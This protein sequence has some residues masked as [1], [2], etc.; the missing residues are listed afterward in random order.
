MSPEKE[1]PVHLIRQ[2]VPLF[3]IGAARSGTTIV[4]RILDAHPEILMTNE[5]TVFLQLSHIIE[6]SRD[7]IKSGVIYGKEYH[8]LWADHLLEYAK[9]LIE[10]YYAKIAAQRNAQQL[11]YWGDKH[12]HHS[13][14][15]SFID[16]LYPEARYIYILRDPR[17]VACSIAK[18]NSGSF[19]QA[20]SAWK[21]FTIKYER[22]IEKLD[23]GRIYYLR[24]EELVGD[25]TKGCRQLL[26]WLGLDFPVQVEKFLTQY[27]NIDAHAFQ[28]GLTQWQ[29]LRLHH[30]KFKDKSVGRWKR[31]TSRQDQEE[32]IREVG[33][34]LEKYGYPG[35]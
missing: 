3:P 13:S 35:V 9:D 28:S 18:M 26:T 27:K 29:T 22:F 15:L 4:A 12:P 14:C 23:P 32:A 25:Y 31:E 30:E 10:E 19:V 20:L 24:Y 34:Y 17:D 16:N 33:D 1:A 6:K 2:A 8:E 11:K 5:T 21:S 7:G